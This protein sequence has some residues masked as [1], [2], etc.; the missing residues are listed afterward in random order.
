MNVCYVDIT[1]H[2]ET[3]VRHQHA[4]I[5]ALVSFRDGVEL[6]CCSNLETA[7]SCIIYNVTVK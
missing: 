6:N 4:L 1:C 7:F 5:T 3:S 2:F